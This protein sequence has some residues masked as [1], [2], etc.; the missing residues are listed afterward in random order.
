MK[1]LARYLNSLNGPY[2]SYVV[3]LGHNC[4][5]L[6][7]RRA[8]VS[9]NATAALDLGRAVPALPRRTG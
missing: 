4:L 7:V 6:R 1:Q 3:L 2:F 9:K 8:A 5:T